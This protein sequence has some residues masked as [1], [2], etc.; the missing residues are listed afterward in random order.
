MMRPFR[1]GELNRQFPH[2][3]HHAALIVAQ[4][5]PCCVLICCH[6]AV[7]FA[8]FLLALHFTN[9]I[10]SHNALSN[11]ISSFTITCRSMLIQ[12]EIDSLTKR[13]KHAEAAYVTIHQ[14]LYDAPD[15]VPILRSFADMASRVAAAEQHSRLQ[16]QEIEVRGRKVEALFFDPVIVVACASLRVAN[17]C[18]CLV[19]VIFDCSVPVG[20][21]WSGVLAN[22]ACAWLYLCM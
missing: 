12:A 11:H 21:R 13:A 9:V 4:V 16:Q 6:E 10:S 7:A 8:I 3:L 20:T 2:S 1:G 22:H 17:G 18:R 19:M 15:V 14:V 5:L